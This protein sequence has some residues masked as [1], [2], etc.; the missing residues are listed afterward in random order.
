MFGKM[1]EVSL[2]EDKKMAKKKAETYE[3]TAGEALEEMGNSSNDTSADQGFFGD[4][5]KT[6]TSGN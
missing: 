1:K 4:L 3:K 6:F 5:F 2:A